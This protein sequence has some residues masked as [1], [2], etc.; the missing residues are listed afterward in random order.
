MTRVYLSGPMT[1]L[2]DNNCPAFHAT[3][4]AL[5]DAGHDVVSPHE[6]TP[7]PHIKNPKWADYMRADLIQMMTCNTVALLPGWESSAGAHLE[8]HVAHRLGMRVV[9]VDV[10]MGVT[11]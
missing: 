4:S 7:P 3:A 11:A 9:A 10:L 8:L 1:G 6:I 2:T 5:R